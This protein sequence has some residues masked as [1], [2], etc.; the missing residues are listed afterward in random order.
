MLSLCHI[1]DAKKESDFPGREIRLWFLT[2]E[3]E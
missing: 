1:F 3:E 2:A